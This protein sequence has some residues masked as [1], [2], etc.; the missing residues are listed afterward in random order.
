MAYEQQL[1]VIIPMFNEAKRAPAT[2]E[3]I[4]IFTRE[5]PGMVREVLVVDDGSTD[6]TVEEVL[7][8]SSKIKIR[9]LRLGSN[10]GKWAAIHWGLM[11]V[12][13]DGVLL[14]DADGSASIFELEKLDINRIF[15][16]RSAVFG[17][18]FLPGSRVDGKNAAR[19]FI[20]KGYRWYVRRLLRFAAGK[21][22]VVDDTQC[23]FKLFFLSKLRKYYTFREYTWALLR[24]SRW[25]GD[26]EIALAMMGKVENHPV[27]F[28]HMRGSK[29][30]FTAIFEMA[31]ESFMVARRFRRI[32]KKGVTY[33]VS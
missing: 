1:T 14:L 30:P 12:V 5:H 17:S 32:R 26:M 27:D 22:S 24:V 28:K 20:S 11:E 13:T 25:A 29:I 8:F 3:E 10:C 15:K 4:R 18:R 19:S 9:V 2:L 31:L 21:G 33:S 16:E 6:A 7:R 23:P